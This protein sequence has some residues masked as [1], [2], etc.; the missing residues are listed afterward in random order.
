M[1]EIVLQD[2]GG[3]DGIELRRAAR[4]R[5]GHGPGRG[6]SPRL[7]GSR[8][9]RPTGAPAARRPSLQGARSAARAAPDGPPSRRHSAAARPPAAVTSSRC[10]TSTSASSTG[11]Q[12]VARSSTVSGV[13][14]N[15]DSSLSATP[16]R[17]SPA[18]IPR[19]RPGR[20]GYFG[21]TDVD[22]HPEGAR[23]PGRG[24]D[25]RSA[26]RRARSAAQVRAR[27]LGRSRRV[28]ARLMPS[29]SSELCSTPEASQRRTT[30]CP[31]T[32]RTPGDST[33]TGVPS[34]RSEPAPR[35]QDLAHQVVVG[36]DCRRPFRT[37]SPSA[38]R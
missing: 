36:A 12:P 28:S 2:H 22:V 27:I 17:R 25:P 4:I 26:A 31:S 14:S 30:L 10:A 5:R 29:A 21:P 32:L 19:T 34:C 18:S 8:A 24:H 15:R 11:R 20:P 13:A 6:R 23:R 35:S 38:A 37:R 7:P 33:F 1:V 9:A 16:M 3:R